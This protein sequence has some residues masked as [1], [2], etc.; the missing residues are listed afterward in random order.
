MNAISKGLGLYRKFFAPTKGEEKLA[1]ARAKAPS[2]TQLAAK[3]GLAIATKH[4]G[5]GRN[6]KSR[7]DLDTEI[8]LELLAQRK[9]VLSPSSARP[10]EPFPD[11]IRT[12]RQVRASAAKASKPAKV[13]RGSG[14]MTKA[15]FLASLPPPLDLTGGR[16]KLLDEVPK[17]IR[18]ECKFAIDAGL[19]PAGTEISVVKDHYASFRTKITKWPLAVFNDQYIEHYLDP[20]TREKTFRGSGDG[21]RGR[22]TQY[23]DRLTRE[24][25]EALLLVDQLAERH[26][27]NHSD[28]MVDH[29]DVGYYMSVS[30]DP[31]IA[32]A[33]TGLELE[34]DKEY[35][36]LYQQAL[37]DAKALG[38][39]C[40]KSVCGNADLR[41]AG[42]W[43]MERLRKIAVR[44]NGR[45]VKY[46]KKRGGWFPE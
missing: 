9:P 17:R 22:R 45:P 24:L 5:G 12:P 20:A 30:A 33:T 32:A 1:P 2:K 25:N 8:E 34:S 31:V 38:P 29:F 19:L 13:K 4:F 26:N 14:A 43:C 11:G 3:R 23:D 35:A 28:A 44:A 16:S 6:P 39:A 40:T 27:Y 37:E 7:R 15:E 18:A 36:A 21:E 42:K 10:T 46:D 41:A